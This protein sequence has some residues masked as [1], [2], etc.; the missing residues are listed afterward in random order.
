MK[1][2]H[3]AIPRT[4]FR[5]LK[6]SLSESRMARCC[7][8]WLYEHRQNLRRNHWIVDE[9]TIEKSYD[10]G[11]NPEISDAKLHELEQGYCNI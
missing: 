3:Q 10:S 2:P 7:A 8:Q 5:Y 1:E 6:R 4:R 9:T 11:D